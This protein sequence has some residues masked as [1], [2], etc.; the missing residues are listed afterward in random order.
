MVKIGQKGNKNK[1]SCNA[2]LK[3][4]ISKQMKYGLRW[5]RHKLGRTF[6]TENGKFFSISFLQNLSWSLKD[7]NFLIK[8]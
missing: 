2:S 5:E 7:Q 1:P 3:I 6:E 8:L 4:S